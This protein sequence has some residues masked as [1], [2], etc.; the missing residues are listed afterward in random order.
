MARAWAEPPEQTWGAV[1]LLL[2]ALRKLGYGPGRKALGSG[3]AG[4]KVADQLDRNALDMRPLRLH[5]GCMAQFTIRIPDELRGTI[6]AAAE[7]D[8]RSMNGEITWL[9]RVGIV[10]RQYRSCATTQ[11][12]PVEGP[13]KTA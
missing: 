8:E 4:L 9:L 6:I 2:T 13:D 3:R 10:A 11:I 1:Q 5:T 12:S 7:A